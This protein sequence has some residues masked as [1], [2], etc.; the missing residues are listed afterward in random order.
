M[1]RY[2]GPVCRLC[3]SEQKKIFLKGM[4]CRSDKC[5]LNQRHSVPGKD[6]KTHAKKRTEYDIQLREKQKIKH[7]Y[8]MLEKQFRLFYERARHMS[9][10]TG[11]NL[12][13]LLESRLDNVVYRMCFAPSRAA[14]RQLVSHGHILVNGKQVNISSYLVK[15]GD[16]LEIRECSKKIKNIID[17]L[18]E[19]SKSNVVSWIQLDTGTQRGVF[20]SNPRREEVSD[21]IDIK[22][23]LV[24]ELYS[25]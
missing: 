4:R 2:T 14:G 20:V 22:E 23:Q 10:V 17:S 16:V 12:V 6:S 21:L 8:N 18:D 15:P 1:A 25:K 11:D 5:A 19:I 7:I 3:R 9:G 24:V 13:T